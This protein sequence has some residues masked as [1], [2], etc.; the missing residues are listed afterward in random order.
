MSSTDARVWLRTNGYDDIADVIDG[1]LAAWKEAGK[2]TRRN[3][4]D[5]LAGD[6]KGSPRMAGG[7]PLPVLKAA[8]IRQG[9]VLQNGLTRSENEVAP[10]KLPTRRWPDGKRVSG[11]WS[12]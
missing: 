11:S 10:P 12:R 7:V 3:W 4:W 8:Q 6:A 5:I 1:I 9:R 2:K